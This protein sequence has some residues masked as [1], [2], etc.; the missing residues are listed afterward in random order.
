M[1]LA[2]LRLREILRNQSIRDPLTGLYNRRYLEE[3]FDRE[4]RRAVRHQHRLSVL[5]LDVDHFKTFNDRYG[6]DAGD[7]VLRSLAEVMQQIFRGED[8]VCRYG[9]EEFAV[10]LSDTG[11][12]SALPIAAKLSERV[13]RISIR[14]AGQELPPITISGGLAEFPTDGTAPDQLLRAADERLY[15]AKHTGRNRILTSAG[16][17]DGALLGQHSDAD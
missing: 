14:A 9:G 3:S 7:A 2:N 12:E 11:G 16:L 6:H 4:L 1:A 10:I 8:M 5:M 15:E 13:Q 17:I